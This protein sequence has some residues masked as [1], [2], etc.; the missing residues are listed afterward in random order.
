MSLSQGQGYADMLK[1]PGWTKA[2]R[3]AIRKEAAQLAFHN[4]GKLFLIFL[5]GM[6]PSLTDQLLDMVKSQSIAILLLKVVNDPLLYPLSSI[7]V[8]H[9]FVKLWR[10]KQVHFSD[11]M[12]AFESLKRFL[13]ALLLGVIVSFPAVIIANLP[14]NRSGIAILLVV[15]VSIYMALIPYLFSCEPDARVIDLIV[16]SFKKMNRFF[17]RWVGLML[18]SSWWILLIAPIFIVLVMNLISYFTKTALDRVDM[19]TVIWIS[20]LPLQIMF[21]PY[22][23]TIAAGY[24]S[25]YILGYENSKNEEVNTGAIEQ[26]CQSN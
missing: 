5:I 17:W 8:V 4:F 20:M 9:V 26:D 12:I 1:E 25:D 3:K 7:G 14:E 10:E 24:A 21:T 6:I 2:I 15:V 16:K 23:Q 22:L 11:L 13:R 19:Q 18:S